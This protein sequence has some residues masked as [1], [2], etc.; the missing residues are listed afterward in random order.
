[1]KYISLQSIII[2][3]F[4]G[5]LGVYDLQDNKFY[6]PELK[7]RSVTHRQVSERTEEPGI[8][9]SIYA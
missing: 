2:V 7:R 4:W 5:A 1:M 6:Y 9:F 3:K 8:T